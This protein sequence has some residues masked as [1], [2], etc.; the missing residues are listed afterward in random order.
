MAHKGQ[1]LLELTLKLQNFF[2]SSFSSFFLPYLDLLSFRPRYHLEMEEH[3]AKNNTQYLHDLWTQIQ[4]FNINQQLNRK[5]PG[6]IF[7][8]QGTCKLEKKNRGVYWTP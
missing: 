5:S 4:M 8:Y 7:F 2:V 1:V 3:F 6:K